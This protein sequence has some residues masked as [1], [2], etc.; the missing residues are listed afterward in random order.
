MASLL[1][2]IPVHAAFRCEI[3]ADANPW[4]DVS[5]CDSKIRSS[6]STR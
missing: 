5:P 1:V 3:S 2:V 6:L 4:A